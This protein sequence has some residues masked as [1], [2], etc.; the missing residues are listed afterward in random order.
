[1]AWNFP[2][3]YEKVNVNNREGFIA[4]YDLDRASFSV[5]SNVF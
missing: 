1:M 4:G 3:G 5:H 2:D